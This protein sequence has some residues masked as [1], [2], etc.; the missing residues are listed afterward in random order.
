MKNLVL[1]CLTLF[2]YAIGIAQ[3]GAKIEFTAK[4]NTIDFGQISRESDSGIRIFEFKNTGNQPLIINNVQAT[5]GC[6][7]PSK[8]TEPILPGQTGQIEVK[9]NMNM[10]VFSKSVIV[11]C[12]AINI[13]EGKVAIKIKGEVIAKKEVNPLEK[14]KSL[15]ENKL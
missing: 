6:T 13:T 1:I 10:G 2:T 12:N 11:D 7:V 5:C 15:M 8:P 9:Y 3:D 4:D 14:P